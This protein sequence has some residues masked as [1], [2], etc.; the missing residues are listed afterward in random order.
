MPLSCNGVIT[1]DPFLK[2]VSH[3]KDQY[4]FQLGL[5]ENACYDTGFEPYLKKVRHQLKNTGLRSISYDESVC[6]LV[7]AMRYLEPFLKVRKTGNMHCEVD[8]V[9]AP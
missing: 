3:E 7:F 4:T 5:M 1:N 8:L 2:L 9:H 6:R